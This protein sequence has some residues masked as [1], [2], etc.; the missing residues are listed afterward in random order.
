MIAPPY[1]DRHDLPALHRNPV[2][3]PECDKR[4]HQRKQ[5]GKKA[6]WTGEGLVRG[7]RRWKSWRGSDRGSISRGDAQRGLPSRNVRGDSQKISKDIFFCL[8]PHSLRGPAF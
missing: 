6:G 3:F 2:R 8:A 4:R 1:R 5:S 7:R